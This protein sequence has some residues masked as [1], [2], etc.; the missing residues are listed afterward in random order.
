[1]YKIAI[2]LFPGLNTEF[3]T[4]R[5]IARA[6][7][8]G[9]FFRWN[10]KAS[11]LDGYDG[12]VI[13][14]GF[15]YEDRSRA[16]V[17]A[18]LDPLMQKIKELAAKGK[19]ILGICNGA[20]IILES[21]L[22]PGV[23]GDKLVMALATNRRI[24]DG[25]LLGT[26]YYNAWVKV[27]CARVPDRCMF[28]YGMK[29]GEILDVPVAHGEG[30]FT[31]EIPELMPTLLEK[32]QLPLRYCNEQGVIISD[33]PVNP[34]GTMFNAAAICNPEGNV[35]AVMPHLER[36][37]SAS[38]K[39]FT[40]MRE[41]LTARKKA[42]TPRRVHNLNFKEV[43]TYRLA[44]HQKEPS[45]LEMEI[46]LIITDNTAETVS[47]TMKEL[48]FDAMSLRRFRH[49][50][51]KYQGKPDVEKLSRRLIQSGVFMNTNKEM[52][53]MRINKE[54]KVFDAKREKFIAKDMTEE[55]NEAAVTY[56]IL[57]REKEDFVGLSNQLTIQKRLKMSE[58]TQ[59]RT[60]TL[61]EVQI[62]TKSAAVAE[63]KL[64]KLLSTHI[65]FNP[66]R[67]AAYRL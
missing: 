49:I 4:R 67:H 61:W 32:G 51:L 43:E 62:P 31:T 24:Q 12:I 53:T 40:S 28:T 1:M 38:L 35:M 3:E 41:A 29:Q 30:R 5:E 46:S 9:E 44:A 17:I 34:N 64:K 13:G 7:M 66:H 14:G 42:G 56:R 25:Q 8:R 26:G 19:P 47:M 50:E 48:G 23:K 36:N 20:Q 60:G 65:F 45:T 54:H 10:E 18:S 6:G 55:S 57:I 15:A 27:K 16:G 11:K 63:A 33:F 2:I 52:A 21:G 59:V 39:L 37:P 22:I 58:V